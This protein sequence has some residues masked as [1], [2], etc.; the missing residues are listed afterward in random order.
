MEK[1]KYYYPITEKVRE[2]RKAWRKENKTRVEDLARKWRSEHPDKVLAMRKEQK[3][4][5]KAKYPEKVTAVM[6]VSNSI[7]AGRLR[8]PGKC[9]VCETTTAVI[10]GHHM[11]YFRPL[12]LVWLCRKC[13]LYFHHKARGA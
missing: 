6:A 3:K 1:K 5:Y 9:S 10:E 13:Y 7:R 11:D 4:R 12:D 2:Y 8:R